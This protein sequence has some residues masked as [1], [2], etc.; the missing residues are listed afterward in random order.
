MKAK[1]TVAGDNFR[2]QIYTKSRTRHKD[3]FFTVSRLI[4]RNGGATS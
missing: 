1:I 4:V 2:V 3:G